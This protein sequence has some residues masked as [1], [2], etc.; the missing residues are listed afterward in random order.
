MNVRLKSDDCKM[1][2]LCSQVTW[3]HH[4]GHVPMAR[5]YAGRYMFSGDFLNQFLQMYDPCM[6]KLY[7]S[8]AGRH[9]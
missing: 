7:E 1:D 4:D 5:R 2:A 9:E 3:F 8:G 6:I